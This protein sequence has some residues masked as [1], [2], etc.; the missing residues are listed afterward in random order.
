MLLK[1]SQGVMG[2]FVYGQSVL[3]GIEASVNWQQFPT[4][5]QFAVFTLQPVP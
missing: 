3:F 1:V 5:V 4:I 2:F